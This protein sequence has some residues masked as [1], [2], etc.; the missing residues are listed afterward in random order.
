[1]FYWFCIPDYVE[2]SVALLK[3]VDDQLP[4]NHHQHN[5]DRQRCKENPFDNASDTRFHVGRMLGLE[6]LEVV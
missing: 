4:I 2:L 3:T 5:Q 6:I 1:M